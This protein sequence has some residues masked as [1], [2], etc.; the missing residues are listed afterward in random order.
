MTHGSETLSREQL[1]QQ[2]LR[3]PEDDRAYLAEM[4]EVSLPEPAVPSEQLAAEW[5]RE[6]DRRIEAY[7][8]GETTATSVDESI[9][10]IRR[11]LVERRA[12]LI[13]Q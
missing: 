6:I 11:A 10:R 4:L 12:G 2:A 1:L 8:R 9:E 13:Q 7:L 5:S 3:M